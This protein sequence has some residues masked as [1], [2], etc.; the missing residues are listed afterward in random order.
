M[1]STP[2]SLRS[3][4]RDT[5]EGPDDIAEKTP[6]PAR[7]RVRRVHTVVLDHPEDCDPMGRKFESDF[8]TSKPSLHLFY[9]LQHVEHL[10]YLDKV[11]G[12]LGEFA[13]TT[14]W[15]VQ[16]ALTKEVAKL[17]KTDAAYAQARGILNSLNLKPGVR[18][19]YP[20]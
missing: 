16:D 6:A 5:E 19:E 18:I 8:R 15:G 1:T 4:L 12:D 2:R 20:E 13:N 3:S 11:I 10:R 9:T 7:K 17:E 14:L